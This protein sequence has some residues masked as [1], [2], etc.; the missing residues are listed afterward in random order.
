VLGSGDCPAPPCVAG[1]GE[2]REILTATRHT[3]CGYMAEIRTS[4]GDDGMATA[5]IYTVQESSVLL[6]PY[7]V[8][9]TPAIVADCEDT[10]RA[11]ALQALRAR[12]GQEICRSAEVPPDSGFRII[13]RARTA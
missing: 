12:F 4:L 2:K 7:A 9:G 13:N 3:F 8:N 5:D 10:A 6:Q 1:D 11:I